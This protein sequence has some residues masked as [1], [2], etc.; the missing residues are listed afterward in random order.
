MAKQIKTKT[1][2]LKDINPAKYNPRTISDSSLEKLEASIE[3]FG[4]IQPLIVNIHNK[5]NV[6]VGGH[7]RLKAMY[8]KG[9]E[10]CG[11]IEVDLDEAQEKALNITLNNPSNQ[12]EF[13][14]E[15]KDMLEELEVTIPE[16]FFSLGLNTVPIPV[17][18]DNWDSDLDG[19][20]TIPEDDSPVP[21][22]IKI[23]CDQTQ[24]DE[25][26]TLIETALAE[27]ECK[28]E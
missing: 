21:S 5:T 10:E 25:I 14:V 1:W 3:K 18:N 28:I 26:K 27:Y 12:G 9:Y 8:N 13:T 6:L 23:H 19:V 20:G 24:K 4:L 15:V 2:K 22:V 16:D 17:V 11:V 7:Q